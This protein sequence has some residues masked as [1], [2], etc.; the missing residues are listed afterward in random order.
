MMGKYATWPV[1]IAWDDTS[2][3]SIMKHFKGAV[4]QTK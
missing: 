4:Y 2:P 1:K 3:E